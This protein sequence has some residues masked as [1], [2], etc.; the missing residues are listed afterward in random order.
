[1][2]RLSCIL[3]ALMVSATPHA[4]LSQDLNTPVVPEGLFSTKERPSVA[5]RT[6]GLSNP[7]PLGHTPSRSPERLPQTDL[8][9]NPQNDVEFGVEGHFWAG[10]AMKL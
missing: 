9:E 7:R 2:N 3:V 4:G 1:M 6:R 8:E 10:L 5:A